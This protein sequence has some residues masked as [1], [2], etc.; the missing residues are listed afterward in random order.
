[1]RGGPQEDIT[2]SW[3]ELAGKMPS[4]WNCSSGS[5]SSGGGGRRTGGREGG[6][7]DDEWW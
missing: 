6:K 7:D 4:K 2:S 1:M 5:R 3:E